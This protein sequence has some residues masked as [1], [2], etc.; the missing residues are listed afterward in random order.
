[1]SPQTDAAMS[2]ATPA[3][4][5]A[6][7]T[8]DQPKPSPPLAPS[9]PAKGRLRCCRCGSTRIARSRVQH[10]PMVNGG[11]WWCLQ[12][13]TLV[14]THRPADAKFPRKRPGAPRRS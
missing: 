9:R 5:R 6:G 11:E 13:E 12:C 7:E 10:L 4:P 3:A 1:M 2:K 14:Y 8:T